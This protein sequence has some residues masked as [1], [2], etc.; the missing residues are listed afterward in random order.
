MTPVKELIN[1]ARV[2]LQA[3]EIITVEF[4]VDM[5]SLK[6][7]HGDGCRV[8]EPGEYTLMT[9]PSSRDEDLQTVTVT[10]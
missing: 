6:A 5:E 3:G 1:F 4:V 2:P 8:L 9:G 7:V 10:L